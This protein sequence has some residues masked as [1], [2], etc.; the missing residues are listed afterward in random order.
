MSVLARALRVWRGPEP[1]LPPDRSR[2]LPRGTG[3]WDDS[4]WARLLLCF[5]PLGAVGSCQPPEA[6]AEPPA[7][8]PLPPP[9]PYPLA[10][11]RRPVLCLPSPWAQSVLPAAPRPRAQASGRQA[12]C[13]G[14]PPQLVAVRAPRGP[15]VQPCRRRVLRLRSCE[16]FMCCLAQQASEKIDRYR[17]HAAHVFLT[18]LHAAGPAGPT[19]PHVP[20]RGDLEQLFPRY[21]GSWRPS[22]AGRQA[23]PAAAVLQVRGGVC[24]LECAGPGL[25]PRHPAAGAA[26][27]PLP[28]AAGAGRVRGR[29][30]GVHGERP[31]ARLRPGPRGPFREEG[32]VRGASARQRVVRT[33]HWAQAAPGASQRGA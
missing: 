22:P 21:W 12:S 6:S 26:L 3:Q 11:C 14:V 7:R 33:I 27:L 18:L 1:S 31:P 16:W 28:R 10:T 15:Q 9:H 24:E 32:R 20:H 8:A 13:A 30:H 19:V 2:G 5:L 23:P 25:P 17:A 4:R 29:P